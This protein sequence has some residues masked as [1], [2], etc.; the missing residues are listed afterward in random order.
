MGMWLGPQALERRARGRRPPC[1]HGFA[2]PRPNGTQR[3]R[4]MCGPFRLSG[5]HRGDD[6][7]RRGYG[8]SC[9]R[10][11][12][13]G[14]PHTPRAPVASHRGAR[15]PGDAK[16][17]LRPHPAHACAGASAGS[18]RLPECARASRSAQDDGRRWPRRNRPSGRRAW[19]PASSP[20]PDARRR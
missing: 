4:P 2:A 11:R 10:W 9:L 6:R 13:S 15:V 20:G 19:W 3:S 17:R 16:L 1:S 8:C 12:F 14:C 18:C 5:A 7:S